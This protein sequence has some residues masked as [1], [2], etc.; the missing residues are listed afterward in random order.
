MRAKPEFWYAYS[1]PEAWGAAVAV[2]QGNEDG[3]VGGMRCD[4]S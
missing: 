4:E 3:L 2:R 1:I